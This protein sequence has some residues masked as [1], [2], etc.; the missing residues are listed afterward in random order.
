MVRRK[1]LF[2]TNHP[3]EGASSRF[4]VYQYLPILERDGFDCA[5]APFTSSA[6]YGQLRQPGKALQK[7]TGTLGA[8]WRRLNDVRTA[9]RYDVVV[10]H[11]EAVP[12]GP[13][14]LETLLARN[15][16]VVFDFDDAL[17]LR[18]PYADRTSHRHLYRWKYGRDIGGLLECCRVVLAGSKAL[19]RYAQRYN[20]RT[21]HLP[22]VIDTSVYT[23]AA[24]RFE[25]GPTVRI[26]WIGSPS[27]A[28]YLDALAG[29]FGKLKRT[30]KDMVDIRI[31]GGLL[32]P[33]KGP[34]IDQVPWSLRT[35]LSELQQFDIGIMPLEENEWTLAK[36]AFKAI[37][38]MAVGIPTVASPIGDA[39]DV[40]RDGTDGFFASS[41]ADW[42]DRL[43]ELVEDSHQRSRL[44]SAA[45]R[46]AVEMF[47]VEA[48]APRLSSVLSKVL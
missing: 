5:V 46:R 15:C 9:G 21:I 37:Q 41:E 12:F 22:T 28:P 10:I 7:A 6:L 36:C 20:P 2:L 1:V 35:E 14:V 13:P 47:S 8:V 45:R 31:V 26:G 3:I 42:F 16:P 24:P 11:R 43:S 30:Y 38:Y 34:I 17:H 4:R 25:E 40:L 23:P 39:K 18:F 27:T 19:E 48:H 32:R 44:G 33:A 29:V